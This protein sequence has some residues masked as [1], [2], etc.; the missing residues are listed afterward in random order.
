MSG[1]RVVLIG[2]P[3]SGKTAVATAL[4]ALLGVET[5]DT[6]DDIVAAAG[7]DIP[8][9]F[10]EDGEE[11]FRR[12]E[13]EAVESTLRG[14]DG[15]LAL[16]G[17]AILDPST[18]ADLEAYAS[19]GG[20]VAYLEV[21]ADVA[22]KRVGLNAARPLLVGNPRARWVEL[23]DRRRGIYERLA[24]VTVRTDEASPDDVAARI[25]EEGAR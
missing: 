14:F 11:G 8:T 18:Q 1:P 20:V 7:R 23:M 21:G 10:V 6:D 13:R 5:R 16:G 17:G 19:D 4:G 15:V 12:L 24:T 9:I 2:P 3:G 22:A 25:V